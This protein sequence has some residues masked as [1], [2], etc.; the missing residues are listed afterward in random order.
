MGRERQRHDAWQAARRS[1]ACRR[2]AFVRRAG[3]AGQNPGYLA[4]EQFY[5]PVAVTVNGAD[6]PGFTIGGAGNPNLKPEKSTETE[7]GFDLGLL[8][9]RVNIEYTHYSKTTRDALVNVNLAPSL[10]TATNRFQ[11]L[12]RVKNWG[13]EAV[14][15]ADLVNR[16]SWKLNVLVNGSWSRNRLLDLGVDENGV[17]IPQF[18]GGFDDTQI[19]KPGLPLG[20]Y[21]I[22]GITSVNDTNKDGLIACPDGPG[23]DGCEF[24]IADSASYSG[25]A[26]PAGRRSTSSRSSRSDASRASPRRSIIAAARR[27]TT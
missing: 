21:Y 10:G 26:V 25:H 9:D 12:G 6:V 7:G 2:C 5:N 3:S 13:D 4:A 11:N 24:T 23:T 27:S 22:R 16:D 14:L 8:N 15:R 18:T 19:F 1:P 20:A 17:P